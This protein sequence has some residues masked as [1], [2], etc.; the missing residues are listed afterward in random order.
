MVCGCC[1][2][3]PAALLFSSTDVSYHGCHGLW[4]SW[5]VA[6]M[7]CGHHGLWPS[8]FVAI[9]VCGHHG[10]WPSWF[11][12]VVV[13]AQ[14]LFSSRPLTSAIMDVMVCGHHGCGHH[15]LRP[16]WFVADIVK[17]CKEED[18]NNYKIAHL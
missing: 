2:R 15:G 3:S 5:F 13:L 8:W 7:V 6:I 11:V 18:S 1:C 9:I 4:P 10:L 12:A 16:S 14:Q 17:P